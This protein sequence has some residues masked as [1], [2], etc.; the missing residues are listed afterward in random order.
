MLY[1]QRILLLLLIIPGLSGCLVYNPGARHWR[2]QQKPVQENKGTHEVQLGYGFLS[3]F[4]LSEAFSN[5]GDTYYTNT[6]G[7]GPLFGSYRF[8]ITDRIAIGGTIGYQYLNYFWTNSAISLNYTYRESLTLP[9]IAGEMKFITID[10]RHFQAYEILG[11]GVT[12]VSDHITDYP[13]YFIPPKASSGILINYQASGGIEIGSNVRWYLE[14]GV[15]YK[16]L[17]NTGICFKIRNNN[18]KRW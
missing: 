12:N 7:T 15:G 17:L 9:A 10:T 5:D 18:K 16:G 8:Y 11:L 6:S 13:A 3:D 2:A 14:L 4:Q 1:T